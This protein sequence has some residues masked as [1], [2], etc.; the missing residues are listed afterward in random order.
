MLLRDVPSTRKPALLVRAL[1]PAGPPQGT[2]A[3]SL[4]SSRST[5]AAR[6]PQAAWS[7]VSSHLE[8]QVCPLEGEL[9]PYR[10]ARKANPLPYSGL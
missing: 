4:T 8:E 10:L 7:R 3:C 2:A 9:P 6:L 5:T 1:P